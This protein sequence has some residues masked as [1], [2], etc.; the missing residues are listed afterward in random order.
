M[1]RRVV[2]FTMLAAALVLCPTAWREAAPTTRG[3]DGG[4]GVPHAVAVSIDATLRATTDLLTGGKVEH[5]T[6]KSRPRLGL[7]V[8][9]G[10]SVLLVVAMARLYR[11]RP[12]HSL[13]L[14]RRSSVTLRAPPVLRL[15]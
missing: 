10:L 11:L 7:A 14:W 5:R 6:V 12:E 15:S 9:V 1:M 8:L 13:T 2:V 3:T 4:V